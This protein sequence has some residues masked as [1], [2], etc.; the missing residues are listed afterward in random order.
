MEADEGRE[1][2]ASPFPK[3]YLPEGEGGGSPQK[4]RESPP[5]PAESWEKEDRGAPQA[6][7]G[8]PQTGVVCVPPFS[9]NARVRPPTT[10]RRVGR[11]R[12]RYT[13]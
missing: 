7:L 8:K 9:E 3:P 4:S 6:A 5:T 10:L 1:A 2:I 12:G 13:I 11:W